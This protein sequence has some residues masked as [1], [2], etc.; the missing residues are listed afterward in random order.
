MGTIFDALPNVSSVM[1]VAGVIPAIFYSLVNYTELL[2][3]DEKEKIKRYIILAVLGTIMTF[4][5]DYTLET[6]LINLIERYGDQLIIPL[7][8]SCVLIVGIPSITAIVSPHIISKNES[9][10]EVITKMAIPFLFN[11]LLIICLAVT[12]GFATQQS[13]VLLGALIPAVLFAIIAALNLNKVDRRIRVW[14]N[15]DGIRY[16]FYTRRGDYCICGTQKDIEKNGNRIKVFQLN[17]FIN[18]TMHVINETQ[19]LE[20]INQMIKRIE[21]MTKSEK[22]ESIS[23][24]IDQIN[25]KV[26]EIENQANQIT[27]FINQEQL[28]EINKSLEEI[29]LILQPVQEEESRTQ[30]QG[31]EVKDLMNKLERLVYE[32]KQK[33]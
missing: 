25:R 9:G 20:Q 22:S 30:T 11:F 27:E 24:D 5:A 33:I 19:E 23:G 14:I 7:G 1:V 10:K 4:L 16:Y 15:I 2:L 21:A 28:E 6:V 26:D 8:V 32:L 12:P 17:E 13:R 31:L 3:E 18:K 29:E